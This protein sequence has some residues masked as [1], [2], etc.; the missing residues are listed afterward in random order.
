M[1]YE[2]IL[3][4]VPPSKGVEI[5]VPIGEKFRFSSIRKHYG[6]SFGVSWK[7]THHLGL[8]QKYI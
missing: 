4:P 2:Q 5:N 8:T 7:W 3:H 6:E 1:I